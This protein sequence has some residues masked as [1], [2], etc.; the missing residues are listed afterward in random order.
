V[1]SGHTEA[2]LGSLRTGLL[3]LVVCLAAGFAISRLRQGA[4]DPEPV[5]F[6]RPAMGTLVEV[7][8]AGAR[9]AAE[10]TAAADAIQDALREVARVDSLFSWLLPPPESTPPAARA[11]EHH[12]L[13]A[14]AFEV[15]HLSGGA[16]DARVAPLVSLWGFDGSEPRLPPPGALTLAVSRLAGLGLPVDV[17]E[18]ESESDLLHFGAWAKGYA[19]DRAVAVLR[20]H[21][22]NAALV[23]AGGDVR[24]FGHPWRVGVQHPRLPGAVLAVIEPGDLA[25]ATSGDYEQYFE[26]DGERY[27][28]LLDP[29][30]GEP[31]RECRSVT[32]LAAD[33]TLADALAT[34]VFVLGPHEGLEL[35]ERQPGV[36]CLIVDAQGEWL[37]STG[38]GAYL[39]RQ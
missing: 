20:R 29:R 35:V 7:T 32:V 1:S 36:E 2:R 10:R 11:R 6:G 8:V 30:V 19:V 38:L 33:C 5:H 26:Q 31:A 17:S 18:L 28:H 22:V 9:T 13:L 16:F 34:A 21:G 15:M 39:R 4:G 14:V 24:G 23:N 3:V 37:E 25:V 12:D 27:H